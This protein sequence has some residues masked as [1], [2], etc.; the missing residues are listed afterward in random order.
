MVLCRPEKSSDHAAIAAVVAAAFGQD[1]VAELINALRAAQ[2]LAISLVAVDDGEIVCH[3]AFSPATIETDA[4]IDQALIL[5]PLAVAPN[6]QRQG[7]G[8]ELVHAGLQAC[9]RTEHRLAFVLGDPAY[10][11]RFGFILAEPRGLV[12]EHG[13]AQAFQVQGFHGDVPYF[14]RGIVRLHPAFAGV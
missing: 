6:H 10:Y 7:I 9:R 4:S 13:A 8:G 11:H 14:S 5:A 1:E 12:W 3:I 2:A